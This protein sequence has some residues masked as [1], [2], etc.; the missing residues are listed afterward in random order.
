MKK[1]IHPEY[2]PSAV[3]TCVC[4]QTFKTGS[5]KKEIGVEIC[6]A[7]HPFFS[8]KEKLIDTAG[9]VDKFK[10]RAAK[11]KIIKSSMPEKKKKTKKIPVK[12]K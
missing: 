12:K 1:D 10:Q 5:T 8:G 9:R 2:H 11:S 3:I 7:C 6:A 4:G